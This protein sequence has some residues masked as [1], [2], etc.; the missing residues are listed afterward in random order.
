MIEWR[1]FVDHGWTVGPVVPESESWESRNTAESIA[2]ND[3]SNKMDLTERY[4]TY[5]DFV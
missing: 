1:R 4:K 5:V 2:N 3:F